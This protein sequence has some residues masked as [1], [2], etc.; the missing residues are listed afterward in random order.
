M[1]EF[2]FGGVFVGG[3]IH[4]DTYYFSSVAPLRPQRPYRLPDPDTRTGRLVSLVETMAD[5][6]RGKADL[7][8]LE[9]SISKAKKP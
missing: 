2:G 1:R 5:Y 4:P 7:E 8:T 9:R 6:A 3:V